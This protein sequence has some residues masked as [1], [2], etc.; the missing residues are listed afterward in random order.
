MAS[1]KLRLRIIGLL[2]FGACLTSTG[3]PNAADTDI[4]AAE[5]RWVQSQYAAMLERILPPS[6][7]PAQLPEPA[8]SGAQLV[9]RYCMQCHYLPNPAM[10]SAPKWASTVERMVW[11]MEGKGNLGKSMH[12]LMAG[13]RAPSSADQATL[14]R[15]LQRHA[16]RE[17]DIKKYADI[18]TPAGRIYSI[19]CSQC[20]VLPDPQRHTAQEWLPVVERMRRNLAW[21][22]RVT[23]DAAMRTSPELDIVEIVRYLQ[24]HARVN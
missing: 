9:A 19:A 4:I 14:L 1:R 23:G 17:L 18:H 3:K 10:H 5:Y 24:R 16:Q 22:N 11:R 8:S 12:E 7:E 20:H 13:V 6:L 15:Y 21:A 2:V